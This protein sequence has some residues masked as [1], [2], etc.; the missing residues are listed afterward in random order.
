M[1]PWESLGH[2]QKCVPELSSSTGNRLP[3]RACRQFLLLGQGD[4]IQRLMDL[5]QTELDAPATAIHRH[6]LSEILESAI[7]G[8]N[9]Q[10]EAPEILQRLDVQ[11]LEL[12]DSKWPV[13]LHSKRPGS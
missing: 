10:Y 1:P 13:A 6:H 12:S 5:L 8:T 2:Y 11:L 9:A 3:G 7:R 4:F